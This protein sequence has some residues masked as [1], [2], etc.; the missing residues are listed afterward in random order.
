MSSVQ[1]NFCLFVFLFFNFTQAWKKSSAKVRGRMRE[2]ALSE[3]ISKLGDVGCELRVASCE[4]R[5]ASC[6][7]SVTSRSNLGE[8]G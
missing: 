7:F 2:A 1:Y 8:R 5:V 6:M 4:L 3:R